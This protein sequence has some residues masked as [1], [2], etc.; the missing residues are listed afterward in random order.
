MM[1]IMN[2]FSR[3]LPEWAAGRTFNEGEP[4]F[5]A[6]ECAL[7]ERETVNGFVYTLVNLRNGKMAILSR[8]STPLSPSEVPAMVKRIKSS[9]LAGASRYQVDRVV[10]DSISYQQAVQ[11]LNTVFREILPQ[12]EGFSVREEQITLALHVLDTIYHQNITLAESEVGTGKT[13]AY[14]V[15]AVIAK[16][17]RLNDG[18]NFNLYPG[19]AYA[20][21]PKMPV[22][23]IT[24]S[25]ALQRAIVTE[26]IPELS[27]PSP[28]NYRENALLY[29]SKNVPVP[30]VEN[31]ASYINAVTDEVERLVIAS[32]GRAAILFTSYNV[33]GRVHAA[34]YKKNLPFPMFK[35]ERSTSNAIERFKESSNGVLFASGSLW[36]GIDIPGDALSMLIIV[37][38]P[39]EPPNSLTEYEREQYGDNRVFLNEVLVPDMF[40]KLKQ[41]FG[42]LI[43]TEKDTGVVAILD[44][45]ANEYG[46]YHKRVIHALPDCRI[47][48]DFGEIEPFLRDKKPVDYFIKTAKEEN[49]HDDIQGV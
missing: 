33:M 20:D 12:Y 6:F 24:S 8:R 29:L 30:S 16:R 37:K 32:Q 27:T 21:M 26:Y 28:F 7:L 48:S 43:R 22:A 10:G 5:S 47:T 4:I 39:F 45:R 38:L 1:N 19:M 34:L 13:L 40:I 42:R 49:S 25:I 44:C 11:L 36:E 17:G 15:P 46:A 14:L 18:K 9:M 31:P 41:G 2:E 3:E 35:L 23:L